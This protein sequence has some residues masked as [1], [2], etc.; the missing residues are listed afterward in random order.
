MSEDITQTQEPTAEPGFFDKIVGALDKVLEK[1]DAEHLANV[2]EKVAELR[3]P[4][5]S[6]VEG[7]L[8]VA[9]GDDLP[10]V[11]SRTQPT[12][13]LYE[14]LFRRHPE[15]REW[16][17]ADQDH[18]AQQWIL[19]LAQNNSGLVAEAGDR[20]RE[21]NARATTLEG[22]LST[23]AVLDGTGGHLLPQNINAV[24]NIARDLN[25]VLPPLC[26]QLSMTSGTL[27]VPTAAAA[28][29]AMV[30]EGGTP[31]QGEPDFASEMLTPHKCVCFM[32]AS[33]E[34]LADSAFN[35][36]S[37][38]AQRA[39]A[40][41][42]ARE[43]V[44]IASSN[45]TAPNITE[46]LSGGNVAEPD[47]ATY[48]LE[49][50]TNLWFAL[51]QPYRPNA[52][53]AGNAVT[54]EAISNVKD[55][56]GYPLWSFPGGARPVSNDPGVVGQIFGRPVVEAPFADDMI[57]FGDFTGYGFARRESIVAESSS[58]ADFATGLVN[59]KF[60]ERFDGRIL[61]TVAIKQSDLSS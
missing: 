18:W 1:R 28:T 53:W 9:G 54:L 20:L 5:R 8:A 60:T 12:D 49:A 46:A 48:N 30:A 43:D 31:S 24:V 32:K 22:D 19:G 33:V 52:T 36:M 2:E 27:R 29:S 51:T 45:G 50:M 55:D 6:G 35:V 7:I 37:I 16:R 25:A 41:I 21:V 10:T 47:A 4:D 3:K 40:S 26:L 34:L 58:H 44:Q 15:Y 39:G 56:N 59:F 13:P 14:R 61:D 17:S 42:A 23:T 57:V 38:Y 11:R